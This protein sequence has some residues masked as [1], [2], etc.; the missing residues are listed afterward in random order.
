VQTPDAAERQRLEARPHA[1]SI[2]REIEEQQAELQ[3]RRVPIEPFHPSAWAALCGRLP[4]TQVFVAADL[5]VSWSLLRALGLQERIAGSYPDA[6]DGL[7]H[8]R[9]W[10]VAGRDLAA[11]LA[12]AAA[13]VF[14]KPRRPCMFDGARW[15]GRVVES[16]QALGTLHPSLLDEP[17][18]CS[19]ALAWLSEYRCYVMHSRILGIH[20]YRI[21]GARVSR[22]D[23]T[24]LEAIAPQLRPTEAFVQEAV[25]RLD[26]SGQS[27]AGYALDIGLHGGGE[28]ALIEMNDGLALANYGLRASDHLDL[29]WARWHELMAAASSE[30]VPFP[31]DAGRGLRRGSKVADRMVRLAVSKE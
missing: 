10:T 31:L 1:G 12:D 9:R 6:L 4:S 15:R 20:A 29:H 5:G 16:A 11:S 26:E 17:F 28:M 13:P 18:F 27:V 24:Q 23:C 25:R 22:I 7:L 30:P 19:E 2:L 14:V 21:G 8:R 3:R